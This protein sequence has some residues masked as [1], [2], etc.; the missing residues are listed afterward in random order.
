MLTS[1]PEWVV[2]STAVKPVST[3]LIRPLA[4]T[5]VLIRTSGV[6]SG[7]ISGVGTVLI[8]ET[9]WGKGFLFRYE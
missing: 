5:A 3:P 9:M 2:D 1:H 6:Y 8:L 4:F 7:Q